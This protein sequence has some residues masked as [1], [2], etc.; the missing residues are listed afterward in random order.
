LKGQTLIIQKVVLE[1]CAAVSSAMTLEMRTFLSP[2]L[3][4]TLR[5]ISGINACKFSH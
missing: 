1:I 4:S 3:I 5:E 2:E